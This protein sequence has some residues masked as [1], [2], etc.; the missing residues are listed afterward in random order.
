MENGIQLLRVLILLLFFSFLIFALPQAALSGPFSIDKKHPAPLKYLAV[1]K[2]V[3]QPKRTE[4][5][6]T[7]LLQSDNPKSLC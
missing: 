6:V 4:P 5:K 2:E 3:M 7:Q 1:I